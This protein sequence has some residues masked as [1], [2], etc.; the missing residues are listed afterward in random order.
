MVFKKMTDFLTDLSSVKER[1]NSLEGAMKD[2]VGSMSKLLQDLQT[3]ATSC[4]LIIETLED[5]GIE[6]NTKDD[7]QLLH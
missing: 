1:V 4:A 7:S 6:I 3:V 5:Y 2:L